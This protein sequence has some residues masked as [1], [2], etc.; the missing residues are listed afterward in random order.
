MLSITC[1]TLSLVCKHLAVEQSDNIKKLSH[2]N[3]VYFSE[4]GS[5]LK[6]P[7]LNRNQ[8]KL[9]TRTESVHLQ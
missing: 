2:Y 4:I 3:T 1:L 7:Q 5:F 6:W 9:T 8:F